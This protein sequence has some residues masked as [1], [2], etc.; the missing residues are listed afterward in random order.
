MVLATKEMVSQGHCEGLQQTHSL[1]PECRPVHFIVSREEIDVAIKFS[2]ERP[3]R[4]GLFGVERRMW[5][6]R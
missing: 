2:K 4:L 1:V 5:S 3:K 6:G